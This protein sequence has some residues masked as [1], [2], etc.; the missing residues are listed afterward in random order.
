[1]AA[2]TELFYDMASLLKYYETYPQIVENTRKLLDSCSIEMPSSNANNRN[3][4]TGTTEGDMRLLQ[5]SHLLD[6]FP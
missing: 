6:H 1:M 5:T 3:S 2:P 4:F